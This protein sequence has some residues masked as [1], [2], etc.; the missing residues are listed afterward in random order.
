MDSTINIPEMQL[1]EL[2]VFAQHSADLEN[3]KC[4]KTVHPAFKHE[5][6]L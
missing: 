1:F 3:K 6:F 4:I 5:Q 2:K